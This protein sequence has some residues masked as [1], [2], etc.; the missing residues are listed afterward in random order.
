MSNRHIFARD[1]I[2]DRSLADELNIWL[3]KQKVGLCLFREGATV[4]DLSWATPES[5]VQEQLKPL[6][7]VRMFCIEFELFARRRTHEQGGR[8]QLRIIGPASELPD[9]HAVTPIGAATSVMMLGEQTEDGAFVDKPNRYRRA[10][11]HYPV[12]GDIRPDATCRLIVQ[13]MQLDPDES[14]QSGEP[15]S[16][17]TEIQLDDSE[18]ERPGK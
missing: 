5:L 6:W 7:I 11:L 10:R 9:G 17:W 2:D 3:P 12:G 15:I 16:C 8:W 4:C 14:G 18:I 13:Q 1:P